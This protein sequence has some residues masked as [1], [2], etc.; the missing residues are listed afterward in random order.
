MGGFLFGPLLGTIYASLGFI[1][2]SFIV[3]SLS[4]KFGRPFVEKF[5][6]ERHLEWF[7]KISKEK[8][9]FTLF[10]IYLLPFFPDDIISY[11][12]GLTNMKMKNLL[13]ISFLGRLPG[14]IVL[15]LVGSGFASQNSTFSIVLLISIIAISIIIYLL[16]NNLERPSNVLLNKFK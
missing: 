12:A 10:L 14:F 7:D 3:F 2:G 5:V 6:S 9:Q 16:R 13:L 8:G 1:V 11:I 15:S 4:R